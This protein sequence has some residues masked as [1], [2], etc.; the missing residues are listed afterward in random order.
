MTI[1]IRLGLKYI[2]LKFIVNH[3]EDNFTNGVNEAQEIQS[4]SPRAPEKPWKEC[5]ATGDS[6]SREELT[7][8][9]EITSKAVYEGTCCLSVF[10][11]YR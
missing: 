11:L 9:R 8:K 5:R 2:F 1:R 4:A 3:L 10:V 7:F 6:R